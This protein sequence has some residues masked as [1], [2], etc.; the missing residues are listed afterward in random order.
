LILNSP[1][2]T[3]HLDL[4][5][6]AYPKNPYSRD[7][8]FGIDLFDPA[9]STERGQF[10]YSQADVSNGGIPYED[11]YFD[12]VSAYDF[13]EHVPRYQVIGGSTAFPFVMLMNEIYRVLKPNGLFIASTPAYPHEK[14]FQDP[15]HVNIITAGTHEYFVGDPPL[16]R[17]YGF[18]GNFSVK[19]VGW[20]SQ[21]NARS[22]SEKPLRQWLRNLEHRLFKQ[23]LSHIT[24]ELVALKPKN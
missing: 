20:D 11:G 16:A 18:I 2:L 22:R 14:A 19:K 4:G 7:L 1:Y 12:S 10:V 3:R 5:C 21:K 24:W 13:L 9:D 6:G 17:C 15:T 8:L 23:G